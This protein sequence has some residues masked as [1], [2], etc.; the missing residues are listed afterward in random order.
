MGTPS[1]F[2]HA[3]RGVDTVIHLAAATRDQPRGRIEEVNGLGTLRLLR[4]AEDAGV[5]RFVFFSALNATRF[6]RTRFM[7]AKAVAEEAVRDA[8]IGTSIFAPSVVYDPADPF[9]TLLRR[10]A[11]LPVLPVAGAARALYQP[12]WARDVARCVVGSLEAA[13]G[14]RY[15]LAGPEVLSYESMARLTAIKAGRQRR[16]VHVP[17]GV[18]YRGLGALRRL[19]GDA[20]F[21]TW[22]EVELLEISMTT[23][24]GTAD[25][26]RLGV[27]PMR[28]AEVLE[29][30]A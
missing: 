13:P 11:L 3:L 17:L 1:S 23:P 30:A 8:D 24:H 5:E 26:R 22:E 6:Q 29:M 18:V 7:R 9:I 19:F 15:E 25:A 12:I 20:V 21:A 16:V 27:E 4:A 28:M 14:E 2:K 10:L